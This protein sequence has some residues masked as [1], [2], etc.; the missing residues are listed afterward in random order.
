MGEEAYLVVHELH[1]YAVVELQQVERYVGA[2]VHRRRAVLEA[3][4]RHCVGG[5][6]V[7]LLLLA[8]SGGVERRLHGPVVREGRVVLGPHGLGREQRNGQYGEKTLQHIFY[9]APARVLLYR[10]APFRHKL[11][12]PGRGGAAHGPATRAKGSPPAKGGK[13]LRARRCND[14]SAPGGCRAQPEQHLGAQPLA[15][16]GGTARRNGPH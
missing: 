3:C 14:F 2:G 1:A 5:R 9:N 7:E 15:N 16:V 13:G 12:L 11:P 10:P 6:Y 8:H 4:H